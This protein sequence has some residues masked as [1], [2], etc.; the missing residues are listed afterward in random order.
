MR[1]PRNVKIFRGGVD[2]APFAGL[3]FVLVLFMMLFGWHVFIP[4]VRV[5]L[6]D[7]S[8][9]PNLTP[10]SV[11]VLASGEV[12]FLGETYQLSALKTELRRR[13]QK[14]D[15]PA[16]IV[17]ESEPGSSQD[18]INEVENLL[19]GS[20]IGI[21]YPGTRME[22]PAG[23]GFAGSPNRVIVVGL[24]RSGQFFFQH[25]LVLGESRLQQKL[26]RAVENAR[27]PLTMVL[28]ADAQVTLEKAVR[29]GDIARRA[30]IAEMIIATKPGGG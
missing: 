4:G 15:L 13:Q 25:Q 26:T 23:T 5:S 20:G 17:F 28:Q 8:E 16:R 10:R 3:F 1:Y 19:K 22:L 2:A 12:L 11:K 9:P 18:E 27:E 14:A 29:L 30:G 7:Q 24:N 6:G 21:K